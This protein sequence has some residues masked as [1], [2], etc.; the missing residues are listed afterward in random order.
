MAKETASLGALNDATTWM[1]LRA[2]VHD[3]ICSS[4]LTGTVVLEY[5]ID[6]GSALQAY[7]KDS[8]AYSWTGPF[9][10]TIE[11]GGLN[12]IEYRL[13][14]SAYTSGSATALIGQG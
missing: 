7:D 13:R 12:A 4:G 6:S 1:N 14:C 11:V 9:N 10:T 8:N 2:G 5:R 3:I